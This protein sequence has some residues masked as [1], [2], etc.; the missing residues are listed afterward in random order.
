MGSAGWKH[1]YLS[2]SPELQVGADGQFETHMQKEEKAQCWN[3]GLFYCM[4]LRSL[5]EKQHLE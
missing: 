4:V 3:S 1:N 2:C 5:S